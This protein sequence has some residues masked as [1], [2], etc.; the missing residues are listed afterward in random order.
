[1]NIPFEGPGYIIDWMDRHGY[2]MQVWRLYEN[3]HTCQQLMI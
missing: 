1:M 2:A 3:L